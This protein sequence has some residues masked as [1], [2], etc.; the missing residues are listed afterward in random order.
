MEGCRIRADTGGYSMYYIGI[1]IH[2]K[3]C[4]VCIKDAKGATIEEMRIPNTGEGI[5]MLLARLRGHKARIIM[6]STSTLWVRMYDA[7]EEAGYEVVLA[8]PYR[9]RVIA[10]SKLKNDS[11]DAAILADLLRADMVATS[12]VPD[13]EHREIRKLIR[14][15]Q[16]LKEQTTATK[17]RI[18]TFLQLYDLEFM[19]TDLFGKEGIA[20][21]KAQIPTL[22]PMDTVIME[23]ELCHLELISNSIACLDQKIAHYGAETEEVHLL[24]TI[25]GVDFF[26]AVLILCEVGDFHRFPTSSHL[27]SWVGLAPRVHQSCDTLHHGR[28]TKQGNRLVRWALVQCAHAAVRWDPHWADI[29]DRIASHAGKKKAIVAVARKLLVTIYHMIRRRERYRYLNL[30]TA[31]RKFKRL[32]RIAGT[33]PNELRKSMVIHTCFSSQT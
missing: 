32:A 31:V 28:I 2:K 23:K 29:Y 7:L 6:E 15:R 12:Y 9:T 14:Y 22:S 8:N 18:H 27:T 5:R 24:M 21:L 3:I 33:T 26:S 4:V 16:I 10:E 17:N 13:K 19:G 30:V 1:D 25:T 11:V 20:W